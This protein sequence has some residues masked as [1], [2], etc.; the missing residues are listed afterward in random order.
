MTLRLAQ[1]RDR[2]AGALNDVVINRLFSAGLTLETAL[3][4]MDSDR[5]A[6]GKVYTAIGE[7]DLV[8]LCRP[9]TRLH[10]LPVLSPAA[11]RR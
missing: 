2:I 7:L 6:A 1:E 8:I 9:N 4:L 10:G 11:W 5:G 3:G